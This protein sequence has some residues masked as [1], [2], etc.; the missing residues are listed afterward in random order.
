MIRRGDVV[1]VDV[2][3]TDTAQSKARPAIVVQNDRDN[4]RLR[5]TVI[6]VITGNLKR[7]GDP[8][9]FLID[10]AT[11]EGVSSGVHGAS[12]ASCNNL[13]TVE[14]SKIRQVIG[15][16]SD[17]LRQQLNDCLKAALELP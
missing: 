5:K 14:Q 3:F 10:P 2:P 4:Q 1:V 13:F 17:V 16:L 11:P 7:L 12:A 9:H 8:S 15:H 6:V